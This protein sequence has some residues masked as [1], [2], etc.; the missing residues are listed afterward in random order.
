[1]KNVTIAIVALLLALTYG[2]LFVVDEG[3]RAISIQFGKVKRDDVSGDTIVYGPGIHLKLPLFDKIK[4]LDARIQTLD[5]E[6]G[7]FIKKKDLIVDSYVKWRIDDFAVY[8]LA[9]GVVAG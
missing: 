5:D 7:R 4:K 3:T 8:Y 9:T 6:P 2:S 1:M